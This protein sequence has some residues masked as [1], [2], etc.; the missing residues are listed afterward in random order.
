M[1]LGLEAGGDTLPLAAELGIRG[2]PIDGGSL[3][4]D[5]VQATLKPIREYGLEVCQI[6]A[7][8]FNPISDDREGVERA[9]AELREMITLAGQ[10][11]C[12][13]IVIGP[14]NH[15]PSGFAHYDERNFAPD[16]IALLADALRPFVSM[17]EENGVRLCVEPYLKG[18]VHSSERFLRL[19]ERVGSDALRCNV[20][21]SS[22]YDF[23][24]AIS[25]Q[26]IIRRTC[27]DLAGHVGLVHIKEVVVHEGFHVHMGLA[28][29]RDGNTDWSLVLELIVPHVPEDGWVILEHIL[30]PE[31]GRQ[32]FAILRSASDRAGVELT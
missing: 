27:G 5:G 8:G 12:R 19:H 15:H 3:V 23:H 16:A 2:V 29:L 13:Y 22:L 28:P 25:P 1:R 10:T 26:Q 32:D 31:Q 21:P 9:G 6:G 14:G 7:F 30:S 17:A 18:V 24:D 11:G 4:R 20:D